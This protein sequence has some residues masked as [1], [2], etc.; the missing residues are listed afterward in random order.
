MGL[1]V[2]AACNACPPGA[3]EAVDRAIQALE[4][5]DPR[6]AEAVVLSYFGGLTDDEVADML[7][8]S[9]ATIKRNLRTARAWLATALDA[10]H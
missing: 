9:P 8:V 10:G 5:V 6:K 4:R 2:L 7:S 1:A 3:H